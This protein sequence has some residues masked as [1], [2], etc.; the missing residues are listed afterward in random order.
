LVKNAARVGN[1]QVLQ[2][3]KE[4]SPETWDAGVIAQA[5]ARGGQIDV[6]K[7]L[8]ENEIGNHAK[9]AS[10]TRICA[11][12]AWIHSHNSAWRQGFI[13]TNACIFAAKLGH[14]QALKWLRNGATWDASVCFAAT[15]KGHFEVLKWAREDGCPWDQYT[16]MAAAARDDLEM[17]K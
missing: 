4:R 3:A 7:W 5:A 8:E 17:L 16:C 6:L 11:S 2:W 9:W 14:L 13:A 10:N 15:A 12:A 1:L